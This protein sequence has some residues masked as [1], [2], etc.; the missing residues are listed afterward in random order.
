MQRRLALLVLSGVI[1]ALAP[2]VVA[3]ATTDIGI[4]DNFFDPKKATVKVGAAVNWS[5]AGRSSQTHNVRE[6]HKLFR[7]GAPTSGNIDFT[8][9]FSA[10][11]F[12]YYCEVH[13]SRSAGMRGL[14]RVPVTIGAAPASLP[15]TVKWATAATNTGSK[16]DVQYRVGSGAWKT[17]KSDVSGGKAT[18]GQ[19][20]APV[21]VKADKSYSF[22]ARSKKGDAASKW[23]PVKSFKA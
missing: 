9:K 8:R 23:S 17:W 10:G 11:T 7:S 15:F 22:R 16:F 5:R 20:A 14:V 21:S 4:S 2:S 1:A 12:S 13:G 3:A 18:F 6:D 19:G